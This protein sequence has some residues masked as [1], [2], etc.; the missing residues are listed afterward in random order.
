M[1]RSMGRTLCRS[2]L[3]NCP[4]PFAGGIH[5]FYRGPKNFI[6]RRGCSGGSLTIMGKR[7]CG[8]AGDS[9]AGLTVLYDR[10]FHPPFSRPVPCTG[11]INR[12]IGVLTSNRVL[13]RECNSVLTNGHA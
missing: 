8:G 2:G 9:G 5:A 4:R 13:I 11:G 10:G 3:V 7:D 1:V 12:L 6:D